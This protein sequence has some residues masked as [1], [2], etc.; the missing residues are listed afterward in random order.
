MSNAPWS[1]VWSKWKSMLDNEWL[2]RKTQWWTPR[3]CPRG[4]ISC[5]L[6]CCLHATLEG[7]L[8]LPLPL[9]PDPDAYNPEDE[10]FYLKSLW[11]HQTVTKWWPT[12]FEGN[13]IWRKFLQS[14]LDIC[15]LLLMIRLIFIR[16]CKL[17]N[18][19]IDME[20]YC[21]ALVS[22]LCRCW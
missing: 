2:S 11:T 18:A 3:H 9:L 14:R 1:V 12:L 17:V 4:W 5:Y 22:Y 7:L 16:K 13:L 10:A 20:S 19:K 21:T 15:N 8:D 6:A